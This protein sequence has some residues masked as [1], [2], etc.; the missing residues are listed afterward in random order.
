VPSH[1]FERFANGPPGAPSRTLD[2][3]QDDLDET[4]GDRLDVYRDRWMLI[5]EFLKY[6]STLS[7]P[8]SL[9]MRISRG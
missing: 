1:I 3:D 2:L 6:R 4:L 8:I 7:D 9:Q 5:T